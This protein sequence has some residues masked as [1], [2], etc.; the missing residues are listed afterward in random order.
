MK[1]V[2]AKP[3]NP[4][5]DIDFEGVWQTGHLDDQCQWI[6]AG[7]ETI[8][9]NK[10]I[11]IEQDESGKCDLFKT[12]Y[13]WQQN[14]AQIE[15]VDSEPSLSRDSCDESWHSDDSQQTS[16]CELMHVKPDSFMCLYHDADYGAFVQ[17]YVRQ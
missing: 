10:G 5:F 6:D 7:I 3:H 17:R 1:A 16:F 9:G 2:F 13:T 4:N 14:G 11:Y 8:E 12:A 15:M